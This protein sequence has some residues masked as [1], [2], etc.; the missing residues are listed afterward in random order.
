MHSI[1]C[2]PARD[3][4]IRGAPRA[5]KAAAILLPHPGIEREVVV[6]A[7]NAEES[8]RR[9]GTE[10]VFRQDRVANLLHG[11]AGTLPSPEIELS[12]RDTARESRE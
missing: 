3:G 10:A 6:A 2:I 7:E 1:S 5:G 9:I 4:T 8:L 12:A 11:R